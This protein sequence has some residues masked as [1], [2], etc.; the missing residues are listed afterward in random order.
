MMIRVTVVARFPNSKLEI[1]VLYLET[2]ERLR[3]IFVL[4][5]EALVLII[6]LFMI[7]LENLE[8]LLP[9]HQSTSKSNAQVF[10]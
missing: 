2:F 6:P 3:L 9:V 1:F 10:V 5:L 7:C 8:L 4:Y